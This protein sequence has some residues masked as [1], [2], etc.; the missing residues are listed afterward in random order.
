MKSGGQGYLSM[1]SFQEFLQRRSNRQPP[2][3]SSTVDSLPATPRSDYDV[4]VDG[5]VAGLECAI[6]LRSCARKVAVI[7]SQDTDI[8]ADGIRGREEAMKEKCRA[9]GIEFLACGTFINGSDQVIFTNGDREVAGWYA[10][11]S[12]KKHIQQANLADGFQNLSFDDSEWKNGRIFFYGT[13]VRPCTPD[14]AL[15]DLQNLSW[16]LNFAIGGHAN[17]RILSQYAAERRLEHRPELAPEIFV[18]GRLGEKESIYKSIKKYLTLLIDPDSELFTFSRR[19]VGLYNLPL[20]VH[21][22]HDPDFKQAY[23]SD[24]ALVRPD[25]VLVWSGNDDQGLEDALREVLGK[26][27]AWKKIM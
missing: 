6:T 21:E 13:A 27:L 12:N 16:R 7:N 10:V 23:Q 9:I 1:S 11:L 8:V 20:L 3:R 26:D 25:K 24:G 14:D 17:P 19:L 22:V 5:T 4:F 18:A 2:S 15:A